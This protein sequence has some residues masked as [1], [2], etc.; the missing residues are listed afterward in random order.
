M[1]GT[2]PAM[3]KSDRRQ[4]S[5]LDC[6]DVSAP[7]LAFLEEDQSIQDARA[8]FMAEEKIHNDLVL[9]SL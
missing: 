4:R 9:D 6:I 7:K 1:L 5:S 3:T 2:E 8:I